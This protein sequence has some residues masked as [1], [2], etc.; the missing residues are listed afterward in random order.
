MTRFNGFEVCSSM[1]DEKHKRELQTLQPTQQ[2]AAK[3]Q[4]RLTFS[5]RFFSFTVKEAF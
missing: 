3:R 1:K 4:L 2:S 5:C